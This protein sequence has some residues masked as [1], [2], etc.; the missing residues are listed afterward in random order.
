MPDAILAGETIRSQFFGDHS[1]LDRL[2]KLSESVINFQPDRSTSFLLAAQVDSTRHLFQ[3]AISNLKT[4]DALGADKA[5]ITRL[6]LSINQAL[7]C[8]VQSV[9]EERRELAA[10]NNVVEDWVPLGALYAE[11]GMY[12]E[13]QSAY[14]NALKCN[15]ALSPLGPAW[16]CFQLGFLWGELTNEPDTEAAAY[17][18]AKAIDYLP[19]YTHAAVHLAE[20]CLDNNELNQAEIL[21][22]SVSSSGDPEVRWRLADLHSKRGDT[23]AQEK[24]LGLA[25]MMYEDLLSRHELAFAD[26]AAEFYLSSGKNLTRARQLALMN[27]EN[28]K[29]TRAY[30]LAIE[31]AEA[32]G[33]FNLSRELIDER[34]TK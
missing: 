9:I 10:T 23:L 26:H 19:A 31:A 32:I 12:E 8:N 17:W 34:N 16:T 5:S 28:R 4:A 1:A 2:V 6:S 20:I 15:T 14:L 11:I 18:Y 7:E 29:T 30:G 21:L 13:A 22:N 24:E 33:D 25:S 27:L 3:S